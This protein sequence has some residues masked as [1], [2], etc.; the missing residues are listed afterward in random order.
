MADLKSKTLMTAA[1]AAS[2]G[3]TGVQWGSEWGGVGGAAASTELKG[4]G[5]WRAG[6]GWQGPDGSQAGS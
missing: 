5:A 6:G 3:I 4:G 2:W 1:S